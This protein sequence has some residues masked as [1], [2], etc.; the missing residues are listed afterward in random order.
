[1][2]KDP[3]SVSPEDFELFFLCCCLSCVHV[4]LIIVSEW[5][6]YGFL[7]K[8]FF[9]HC[10]N[11]YYSLASLEMCYNAVASTQLSDS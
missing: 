9:I 10:S 4:S 3:I 5:F 2:S 1:M 7:K 6:C 8:L 11:K